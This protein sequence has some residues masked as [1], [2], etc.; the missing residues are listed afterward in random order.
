MLKTMA[1]FGSA[2]ICDDVQMCYQNQ[3]VKLTS[4][5]PFSLHSNSHCVPLSES[6]TTSSDVVAADLLFD[7]ELNDGFTTER[8]VS[9]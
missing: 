7:V 6:V 9:L 1:S 4:T 2:Q 3:R 8:S 5:T